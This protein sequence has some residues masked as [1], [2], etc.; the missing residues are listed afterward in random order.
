M[1]ARPQP[2]EQ[3]VGAWQAWLAT[4]VLQ[5]AGALTTLAINLLNP[6]ALLEVPGMGGSR[7]ATRSPSWGPTTSF[8][9]P[10]ARR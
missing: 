6:G 5:V 4:C 10:V 9:L 2:P 8:S 3:I 1:S 7:W